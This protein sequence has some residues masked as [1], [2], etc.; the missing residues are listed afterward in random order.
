M[1][2]KLLALSTLGLLL[3]ACN[4]GIIG[5]GSTGTVKGTVKTPS[6]F[7]VQSTDSK[8]STQAWSA[9][10]RQGQVL[11]TR[12]S[13]LSAQSLSALSGVK[14][15][16]VAPDLTVAFTPQGQDDKS[17]AQSLEQQG[18]TVQPNYLYQLLGKNNPNDP[19]YAEQGYLKTINAPGAWTA[20]NDNEFNPSPVK[21]AVL[22]SGFGLEHPDLTNRFIKSLAKD[23]CPVLTENAGRYTCSGEDSDVT[24]VAGQGDE[25]HGNHV[26]SILGAETN[27]NV[28]VA[29]IT[30]SGQNIIPIKVFGIAADRSY[31][32]DTTSIKR[33]IQYAREQKAQVINISLGV[34][35]YKPDGSLSTD[36]SAVGIPVGTDFDPAV[37]QEIALAQ[38]ANIVI[39]AAAG[40]TVNEG[41]YYPASENGVLAVGAVNNNNTLLVNGDIPGSA[42]NTGSARPTAKQTK[43]IDLV[44]PGL[45][46]LGADLQSSYRRDSGTSEAAPQVAGVAA[47]LFADKPN[48]TAQEVRDAI[49]NS[50]NPIG[51]NPRNYGKGLL[52]AGAAVDLL[53]SKQGNAASYP[54]NVTLFQNGLATKYVANVNLASKTSAVAYSIAGVPAWS[55]I[56][57]ATINLNS[58]ASPSRGNALGET[59]FTLASQTQ[60]VDIETRYQR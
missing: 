9:P 51:D 55:Y 56:A 27:N 18:L 13:G 29:G 25:S 44:A 54:V 11:V 39:V 7:A 50:A 53:R 41:I 57:R 45:D 22:D 10:R 8:V 1:N 47:L 4:G 52:D 19:K 2:K 20:L 40:N 12:S 15:L 28:G 58:S 6:E 43:D 33:G 17:F 32:A 37:R 5:P 14:T 31:G 46:I 38:A 42:A 34:P 23:F 16:S 49:R 30:W 60:T 59:S 35:L 36:A 24:P 26:A 3:A 48:A 21:I